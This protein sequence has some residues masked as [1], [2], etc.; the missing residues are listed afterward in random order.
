MDFAREIM[1]RQGYGNYE[2]MDPALLP[3]LYVAYRTT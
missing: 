3:R 2:P 1:E